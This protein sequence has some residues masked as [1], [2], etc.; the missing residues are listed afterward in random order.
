MSTIAQR[1]REA[2]SKELLTVEEV[3]LVTQ[4]HVQSIYRMIRKGRL[5]VVR[6]GGWSVRVPRSEL[7]AVR[8]SHP[9]ADQSLRL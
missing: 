9:N 6:L 4:F 3:S 2:L 5:K 7:K 8:E 1:Q